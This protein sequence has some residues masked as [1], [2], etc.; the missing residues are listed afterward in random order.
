[1]ETYFLHELNTHIR[2][3]IDLNFGE[4]VWIQAEISKAN[5]SRGHCYLE[6]VDKEE[7]S[8]SLNIRAKASAVIW[9]TTI[10][11]WKKRHGLDPSFI[12][13]GTEI[14]IRVKVD[15]HELY[16]LKLMIDEIDPA[17]TLGKLA[18]QR[19][20]VIRRLQEMQ[21]LDRNSRLQL[22]PVIQRIAI[23]SSKTAA[24]F[25]DFLSHLTDN[26]W[27][28]TFRLSLFPAAMQ[29]QN[30][31][32]EVSAQLMRIAEHASRFDAIV[33]IR[34]GGSPTDLMAFDQ[35]ELCEA[36]AQAPL[37]VL[38]GIGHDIDQPVIELVAHSPQKTPTAVA[39]FVLMHN[40]TFEGSISQI[41]E[42]LSRIGRKRLE[43]E[44]LSIERTSRLLAA[45]GQARIQKASHVLGEYARRLRQSL[46]WQTASLEQ[47]LAAL[48]KQQALLNPDTVLKRGF[49]ITTWQHKPLGPDNMP[50]P[51]AI[52]HTS[53]HH[54]EVK[55]RVENTTQN[56]TE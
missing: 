5:F 18:M 35:L 14:R 19:Q 46:Q 27:G 2:Q 29:G 10:A 3:V 41:G 6:L 54:G 43:N 26:A 49:S 12:A 13:D 34:G 22:P 56:D 21:L 42:Q 36:V 7:D 45:A 33:I 17:F 50:P 30:T 20:E 47:Q 8:H 24:G 32:P 9:K 48:E 55:S 53:V 25:K 28:Y 44:H 16:G 23:I 52:I 37:P 38:T 1:V 51:G 15:F 11:G 40:A 39:D 4:S 31:G